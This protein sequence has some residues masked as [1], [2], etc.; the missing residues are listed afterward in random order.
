GGVCHP[1]WERWLW[2]RWFAH[3][4]VRLDP[5]HMAQLAAATADC[6]IFERRGKVPY[7]PGLSAPYYIFIGRKR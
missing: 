3:D 2:R 4:G 1:A 7:L 6:L 5:G